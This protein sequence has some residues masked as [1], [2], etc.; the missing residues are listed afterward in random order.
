MS[1]S[2]LFSIFDTSNCGSSKKRRRY[3]LIHLIATHP[4]AYLYF[5]LPRITKHTPKATH[6]NSIN[7]WLPIQKS[8]LALNVKKMITRTFFLVLC[9]L[10]VYSQINSHKILGRL[11]VHSRIFFIN[12]PEATPFLIQQLGDKGQFIN[13]TLQRKVASVICFYFCGTKHQMKNWVM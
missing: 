7:L 9:C 6:S 2:T 13:P 8:L 5:V 3:L 1:G 12:L 4:F 11:I 10:Y